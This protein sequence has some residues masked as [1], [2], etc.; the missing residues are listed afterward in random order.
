MKTPRIE[1]LGLSLALATGCATTGPKSF[2][3]C[4]QGTHLLVEGQQAACTR[5]LEGC[6]E[7]PELEI[8]RKDCAKAGKKATVVDDENGTPRWKCAK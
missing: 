8:I 7:L 2:P 6:F 4:P 5:D 3:E 1:A